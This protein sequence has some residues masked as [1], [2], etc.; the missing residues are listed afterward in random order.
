V[1]NW[2]DAR[3]L[4]PAELDGV[5]G[6]AS[7]PDAVMSRQAAA[8]ALCALFLANAEHGHNAANDELIAELTRRIRAHHQHHDD[9]HPPADRCGPGD[10]AG[11]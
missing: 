2:D 5:T 10:S 6:P 11:I 9:H 8:R 1:V 4:M 3:L 7:E